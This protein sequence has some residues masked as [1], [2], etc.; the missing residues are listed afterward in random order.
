MS[1][2]PEDALLAEAVKWVLRHRMD[3]VECPCCGQFAKVYRRKLNSAMAQA[4]AAFYERMGASDEYVHVPSTT[5]M[6]R[7]GGDW[8][9]LAHWGLI[10]EKPSDRDDGSKHAGWWRIT[11]L[12]RRFVRDEVRIPSHALLFN[13][14]LLGMDESSTI[15]IRQALGDKFD[16]AELMARIEPPPPPPLPKKGRGQLSLLPEE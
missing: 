13:Q 5:D 2:W 1:Q 12:G 10:E 6:S 16:Y 14:Q 8:A 9:K 15:G 11:E 3:G 7:L 4:L